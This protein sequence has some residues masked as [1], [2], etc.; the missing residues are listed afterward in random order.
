MFRRSLIL[1]AMLAVLPSCLDEM[2]KP[3]KEAPTSDW[4]SMAS[5][6]DAVKAILW[7]YA[8]PSDDD[9]MTRYE[10]IL[11]SE[12]F[13]QLA[14]EDIEPGGD[15]V[16]TRAEDID[17]TALLFERQTQLELSITDTG[18]WADR[19]EIAGEICGGCREMTRNYYIRAQFGEDG[20]VWSTRFSMAYVTVIVAPDENDPSKWVIRAI[21]DHGL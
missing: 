17:L 6:D 2:E 9:V 10:S 11:H 14:A 13:F 7:C 3:I 15:P 16:I 4:P 8:S 20:T 19:E 1:L 21:C 12:Y 5:E 18:P